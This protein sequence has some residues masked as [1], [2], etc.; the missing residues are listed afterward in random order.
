MNETTLTLLGLA[1]LAAALGYLYWRFRRSPADRWALRLGHHVSEL[2]RRRRE[3]LDPTDRGD[4]RRLA[5]ELFRRHLRSV[6]VVELARFPG[7]GP[8]T[9]EKVSTTAGT[10]LADVTNFPF[11][12]LPGIG[13]VKAGDLVRAVGSLVKEARA[14]FDAGAC[15]EAQEYRHRVAE[16]TAG[17]RERALAREREV[18]AI[19]AALVESVALVDLA[20][21]VT[22]ANFLLRRPVAGLTDEVLVRPFPEPKVLPAPVVEPV[23]P[24]APAPAAAPSV[25]APVAAPFVL[26]P[27]TDPRL[28]KL[29]AVVR[30][31][32]LVAKADGRIAQAERKALRKYLD[33]HFGHDPVLVRHIDPL[34]EATEK[35]PLD[36]A[37]ILAALQDATSD[38]RK[39]L[40]A[41][42]ERLAD[43]SGERNQ[44]EK[45]VLARIAQA[46]GEQPPPPSS[47]P[48][49]VAKPGRSPAPSPSPL[50]VLELPAD[51][52]L[53]VELIRRRYA[54]LSDRLDPTKAA[55]LGPEFAAMAERKRAELRGAAEA[56]I[57]PFGVPL[58]PPP[59]PPPPADIRH[60]PDLDDL[61]G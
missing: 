12:R 11:E 22:F 43:T 17:D 7:I 26:P 39:G 59:A 2:N 4:L 24:P 37:A 54:L 14:R 20:R 19:D 32:L 57:A 50:A 49:P 45:E 33:E 48:P 3:L 28:G 16:L 47:E 41:L 15:P 5:D 44:R 27:T 30:F 13:P 25:A 35:E 10:T 56:L 46:W 52:E 36:E 40:L 61:F 21:Q 38:E 53:S 9:V 23:P 42:A 60:N 55:A 34:M 18:A 51:A 29:R 31:G 8:G 58:D 1:A 6:S